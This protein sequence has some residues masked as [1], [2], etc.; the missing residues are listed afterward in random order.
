MK[1]KNQSIELDKKELQKKWYR[2]HSTGWWTVHYHTRF[3]L[4][5][6]CPG[7]SGCTASVP[8]HFREPHFCYLTPMPCP[9]KVCSVFGALLDGLG[10]WSSHRHLSSLYRLPRYGSFCII[11]FIDNVAVSFLSRW[12]PGQR[13]GVLI[14]AELY[15][16]LESNL[17]ALHSSGVHNHLDQLGPAPRRYATP[18]SSSPSLFF[19]W[20]DSQSKLQA[21]L[22]AV[23]RRAITQQAKKRDS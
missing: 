13:G 11:S 6:Q 10:R 3:S 9:S 18:R 8:Q 1:R 2:G 19:A 20:R 21:Q 12:A 15:L 17:G 16:A 23:S 4:L 7:C 22:L 14:G 5:R